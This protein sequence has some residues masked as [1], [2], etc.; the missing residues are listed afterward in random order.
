MY[1]KPIGASSLTKCH[2]SHYLFCLRR[3]LWGM[4]VSG[5]KKGGNALQ[6]TE[7]QRCKS[8]AS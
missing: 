8:S 2:F 6:A 4:G 3:I 1:N 5:L 7:L